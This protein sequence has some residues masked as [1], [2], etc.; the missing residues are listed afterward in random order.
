MRLQ[1]K[2]RNSFVWITLVSF[3]ASIL[4]A[5]FYFK[6][7][8]SVVWNILN[9]VTICIATGCIIGC[10]QSFIGYANEKYMA[11]IN[12]YKEAIMLEDAIIN[13]P[14]MR[15]GFIESSDGLKDIRIITHRFY[16]SFKFSYQCVFIGR[17]QNKILIAVDLLYK[18]YENQIKPFRD[19]E[20]ALCDS[21]RYLDKSNDELIHEGINIP[22]ET[23]RINLQL[24]SLEREIEKM[25]NER[26]SQELRIKNYEIIE[27]YLFSKKEDENEI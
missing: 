12:F 13:Y 21:L 16:D 7:K 14:F 20:N 9:N 8:D 24:Q 2:L 23:D 10:I 25:Y 27:E 4:V 5:I 6:N 17:S 15:S 3:I 1:Y 18:S 26:E 11:I 19:M 22:A